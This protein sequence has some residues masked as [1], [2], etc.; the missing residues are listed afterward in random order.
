MMRGD[1]AHPCWLPTCCVSKATGTAREMGSTCRITWVHVCECVFSI[2]A[3]FTLVLASI[4]RSPEQA[5]PRDAGRSQRSRQ[6][7]EAH[8]GCQPMIPNRDLQTHQLHPDGKE[9]I[10]LLTNNTEFPVGQ[11]PYTLRGESHTPASNTGSSELYCP[12]LFFLYYRC[13]YFDKQRGD[14]RSSQ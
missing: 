5:A 8:G 10:K 12:H 9:S 2:K 11:R 14:S 13:C 4:R 6:G 1:A 3:C 7:P